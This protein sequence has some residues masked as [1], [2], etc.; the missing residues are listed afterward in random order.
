MAVL[1]QAGGDPG[2]LSAHVRAVAVHAVK[3]WPG[4]VPVIRLRCHKR[5]PVAQRV[6]LPDTTAVARA[7]A[8]RPC[9]D[10]GLQ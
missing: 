2:S 9:E 7:Q 6:K 10:T 1:Q 4:V 3:Q 8:V 5:A